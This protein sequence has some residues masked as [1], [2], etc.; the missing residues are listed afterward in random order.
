MFNADT[1]KAKQIDLAAWRGGPSSERAL[2][3]FEL[4]SFLW[5][6]WL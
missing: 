2:E 1:A 6:N 4:S 5:Q 3:I